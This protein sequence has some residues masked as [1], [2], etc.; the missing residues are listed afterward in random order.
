MRTLLNRT[1][2][3]FLAA[4]AATVGA[5]AFALH[6]RFVARLSRWTRLPSFVAAPPLVPHDPDRDR[7]TLYLARG[8]APH[9]NVDNVLRRLGGIGTLVGRDDVVLIKVS[10][11]WWNQGMTN[12]AA[13]RRMI[14]CVLERERFAGEVIVF[15]NVHYRL[16]GGSGLARAWTHPSERNVDVEGWSTLGDLI[17]HFARLGAPVS[18]VG[19]VDAGSSLLTGDEDP[20]DPLHEHGICGGDGR[21]P[22]AEGEER[23]GYRWDFDNVFRVKRSLVDDARTPLSWPVFSSPRSGLVVDLKDGVFRR[24]AGRRVPVDRKLAWINMTTANE[25]G[26]TGF[27]GAVKSTMGIVDMTAGWMGTHPLARGYQSVHYVGHPSAKWRIA[28]PLAHWARHVRRPDLYMTVAEWVGAVPTGDWD[29][30]SDCRLDSRA[31]HHTGAIVAGT[32]PVA[33]DAWCVKNLL[34]PI[35]GAGLRTRYDLDNPDAQISK[36]LRYYRQVYG[37]GTLALD[38]IKTVG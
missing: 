17:P 3:G 18:F 9:E 34:M 28:G 20:F 4:S 7:T 29:D 8:A 30:S 27:T 2:R 13:V 22:I 14:E 12:V 31:A 24:A 5:A 25:H 36:F 21:G 35:R 11:Q 6:D 19:L 26:A 1:R 16:G 37:S 38:L 15:E 10:A 32:D 23:D 33:I